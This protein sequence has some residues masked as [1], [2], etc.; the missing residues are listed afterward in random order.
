MN[1]TLEAFEKLDFKEGSGS[2]TRNIS[3]YDTYST[4]VLS[5][6]P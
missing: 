2:T 4:M 3:F 6:P 5:E 1:V